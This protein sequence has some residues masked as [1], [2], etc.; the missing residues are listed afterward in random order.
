MSP[1]CLG[2]GWRET[3]TVMIIELP[4][5]HDW[6]SNSTLASRNPY[7]NTHRMVNIR[8]CNPLKNKLPGG[9][10]TRESTF[11]RVGGGALSQESP[12]LLLFL[13]VTGYVLDKSKVT[14]YLLTG[15]WDAK[16]DCAEVVYSTKS[17][18]GQPKQVAQT[19]SPVTLW[20]MNSIP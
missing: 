2:E 11:V 18:G 6:I 7:I 15:T 17:E 5:S 14:H 20:K 8:L 13:K 1:M 16:I 3:R 19:K 12:H 10:V 4:P 9:I